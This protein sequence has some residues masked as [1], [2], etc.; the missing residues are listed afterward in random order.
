M[1]YKLTPPAPGL[2]TGGLVVYE[3]VSLCRNNCYDCTYL[4]TRIKNLWLRMCLIGLNPGLDKLAGYLMVNFFTG[5]LNSRG[6]I[7]SFIAARI[8]PTS[9]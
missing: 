2:G 8:P 6:S 4:Q 7:P 3:I 5:L 9:Q 1:L